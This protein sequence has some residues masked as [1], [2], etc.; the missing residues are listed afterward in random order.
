MGR[1]H[2]FGFTLVEML[3]AMAVLSLISLAAVSALRSF[4]QSQEAIERKVTQVEE[5]RMTL[6][7]IR[8]SLQKAVP[9]MHPKGF[10]TYF[11]GTA[12]EVIWVAP[13]SQVG[14]KGLQVIRLSVSSE[15]ALELRF[16][17]LNEGWQEPVWGEITPYAVLDGNVSIEFAYRD[18]WQGE[19][20]EEWRPSTTSPSALR[21]NLA[22]KGRYWPELVVHFT[23]TQALQL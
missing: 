19:W 15:G 2:S 14:M 18:D 3:I 10:N 11:E 7:F 23:A 1:R 17:P 12:Q 21:V 6:S 4:A 16:L 8:R 5:M 13:M 20:V 22:Y 9:M